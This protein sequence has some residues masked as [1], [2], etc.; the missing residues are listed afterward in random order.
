M[1]ANLQWQQNFKN[2]PWLS[3]I[4]LVDEDTDIETLIALV[5]KSK[6]VLRSIKSGQFVII[7]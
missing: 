7:D 1:D 5:P 6:N 2:F 4:L 3:V